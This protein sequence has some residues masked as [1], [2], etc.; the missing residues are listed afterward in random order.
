MLKIYLNKKVDLK[1]NEDSGHWMSPILKIMCYE[2]NI[3]I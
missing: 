3:N 2:N 1:N